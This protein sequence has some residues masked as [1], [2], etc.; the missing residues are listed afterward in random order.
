MIA[1]IAGK[2]I[3]IIPENNEDTKKVKASIITFVDS[4]YV[5]EKRGWGG[6][7]LTDPAMR[8]KWESQ[9]MIYDVR[10]VLGIT[11]AVS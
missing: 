7:I 5:V 6:F 10:K 9:E 1:K 4:G 11:E 2:S 8:F 3:V